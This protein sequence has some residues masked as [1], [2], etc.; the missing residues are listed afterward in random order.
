MK[1]RHINRPLQVD[2][3]RCILRILS[4]RNIDLSNKKDE[5]IHILQ[6][7]IELI[8]QGRDRSL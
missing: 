5:Q 1:E 2:Y 8:Y 4:F 7:N 3:H 6:A